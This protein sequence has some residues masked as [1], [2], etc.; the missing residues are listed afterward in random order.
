MA[1]VCKGVKA[2]D[3]WSEVT[4]FRTW[5]EIPSWHL[6]RPRRVAGPDLAGHSCMLEVSVLKSRA[7]A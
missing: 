6:W 4:R 3:Y 1:V 7:G 5:R 2:W